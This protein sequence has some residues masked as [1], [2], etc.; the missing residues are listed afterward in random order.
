MILQTLPTLGEDT[1]GAD[2]TTDGNGFDL[3]AFLDSSTGQTLTANILN[4]VAKSQG[5]TPIFKNASGNFASP[6]KSVDPLWI[7]GGIVAVGLFLY[8]GRK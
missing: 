7:L 5:T 4:T 3:Q 6:I 1:S 8:K 2:E